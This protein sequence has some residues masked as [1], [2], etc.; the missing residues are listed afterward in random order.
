MFKY[1]LPRLVTQDSHLRPFQY[2]ILNN[3]LC[4]NQKL[5]QFGKTETFLCSFCK[6]SEETLVLVFSNCECATSERAI[7]EPLV[8]S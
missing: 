6:N 1:F 7:N 2:N 5:F 3:M 4:L 8:Y